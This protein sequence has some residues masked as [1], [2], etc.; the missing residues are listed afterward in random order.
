MTWSNFEIENDDDDAVTMSS[1]TGMWTTKQAV[2]QNG[3]VCKK[4][5]KFSNCV[6]TT[7]FKHCGSS[8]INEH[9]CHSQ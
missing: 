8:G 3:Y 5:R 2:D 1:N 9:E 7:E 4:M 6:A